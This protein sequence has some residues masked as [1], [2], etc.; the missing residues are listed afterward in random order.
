MDPALTDSRLPK[1]KATLSQSQLPKDLVEHL[2]EQLNRVEKAILSG[3]FKLEYDKELEYIRFVSSL[4]FSKS[5]QDIL[6]LKRAAQILESR[7]F[8]L[9]PVKQRILE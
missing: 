1:L 8:G 7:H 9:Q 5:S 3:G 4:P 2:T 6:D